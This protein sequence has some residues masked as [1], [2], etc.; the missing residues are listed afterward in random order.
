M[1]YIEWVDPGQD[2][3]RQE[4]AALKQRVARLEAALGQGH[5]VG[6]RSEPE[7][8]DAHP[9]PAESFE[10]RLGSRIFN[11]IGIVAVLIGVAW[12]LKI[13]FDN[14]W[15]GAAGKVTAGIVAGLALF[16]W[17]ERFRRH[18]YD[19]FSYSLNAVGAGLLYLSLWAAWSL[20][21][22]LSLPLTAAAMLLVT[23]AIGVLAWMRASELLAF[24]AAIGGYLTPL[25]LSNGHNHEA[26]LF[27]YLLMLDAAA[28]LSVAAR[29]WPRLA[30]GAF[31]ATAAY[32]IGWYAV[33]Y[34]DPDFALTLFFA[35]LTLLFFSAVPYAARGGVAVEGEARQS[36]I[37]LSV[38][39]LNAAFA[40]LAIF[41]LFS[42]GARGWAALALCVFYFAL[43][44]PRR[45][46]AFHMVIAN[47]FLLAAGSFAIAAHWNASPALNRDVYAQVGY[48]AW[49]MLF[50]AI[51]LS[52]GFWRRSAA[53]R[54]QGLVLLCVSIA[55]VFL[56]D[57]R[58]LSQGYRVLSFLGLGGLLLAV[59]FVY[60]KDWLSL[61]GAGRTG[62]PG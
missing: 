53:L 51:V 24:Y 43:A 41:F 5:P 38:A 52:A 6:S 28:I 39:I 60:Q 4:I 13:A 45:I 19:A 54:W 32:G 9:E 46:A 2:E 17:S 40:F 44:R 58:T 1:L 50:G 12:F 25:L 15:L 27:S 10:A 23:A 57:M 7:G 11:R 21:H 61:R 34:T 33:Y 59:S 30:L 14:R 22:I 3:L 29:P 49:F 37:A 18:G 55:K 36:R 42:V 20:F 26:P 8:M 35:A 62:N 56:V 31:L 47:C 48:S 16:V